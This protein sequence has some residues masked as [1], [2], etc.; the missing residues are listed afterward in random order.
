MN[1]DKCL[2]SNTANL[3]FHDKVSE[4]ESLKE[5]WENIFMDT[6]ITAHGTFVFPRELF[7]KSLTGNVKLE[8][9]TICWMRFKYK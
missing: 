4:L 3:Q 7:K 5:M 8:I 9:T 6:V 1:P 2:V